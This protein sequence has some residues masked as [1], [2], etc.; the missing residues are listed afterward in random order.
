MM[1]PRKRFFLCFFATLVFFKAEAQDA[2]FRPPAV[3]LV[4]HDPYFSIWSMADHL[5]DESTRHWTGTPHPLNCLL[6]IDGKAYRIMGKTASPIPPLPQTGLRVYPTRSVYEFAGEGVRLTMTFLS[7]LLADRPELLARPISYITWRFA[8]T[9]GKEHQLSV[10]L[11]AGAEIAVNTR[12][13]AVTWARLQWGDLQAVRLGSQAQPILAKAGDDLRIDWGNLYLAAPG[14]HVS[15]VIANR[16]GAQE[17]FAQ[18]GSL[19]LQDAVEDPLLLHKSRSG[20]PALICRIDLGRVTAQPV[21]RFII[22]GYDDLFSVELF[23]QSLQ[24]YWRKQFEDFAALLSAAA[25][26]H[27][28]LETESK[29]FDETLWKRA[30]ASGGEQYAQIVSLAY[31][32]T[33]GGMKL[34]MLPDGSPVLFPKEN[35][36]NGCISTVDVIYPSAPF[37]LLLNPDLLAGQLRPVFDYA[38][39]SRWRFPFA[40]HDLGT[41]PQ[42]NGQVYGGREESERD[43]MPVEETGNMLIMTAALAKVTGRTELADRYW[44][45]LTRWAEYLQQK[46]FDPANQLATNEMA[47]HLE[48][49]TDLSIKAILGLGAYSELCRR[50]KRVGEA[51]HYLSTAKQYAE[52]WIT[53]ANDGDHF[54]LAFDRPRTWSQKHNLIWDKILGLHLF[55]NRVA[56]TELSFYQSKLGP[57]GLPYD[58]RTKQSLIDW[59]IWSASLA[60][61]RDEFET[62]VRPIY[63]FLNETPNRVPMTDWYLTES[64]KQVRYSPDRGFQA[65]TV[66]GGVFSRMLVEAG[67]SAPAPRSR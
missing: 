57:F 40:P 14:P 41:Y 67:Q 62:F 49:N 36:S 51:E 17:A 52:T 33:L 37:F 61:S 43:Q 63:R 20:A 25:T 10:Y 12:D 56:E 15:Y 9:D 30:V 48:H 66:V 29:Q 8:A 59:T 55:P 54:R 60:S 28:A 64:G 2:L 39:M 27:D 3:P 26:D 21:S 34:A 1:L 11:D 18:N 35:F 6:R 16:E 65:R 7:P 23:H 44:D 32:Q 31:R 4:V 24:P 22:L 58:S 53:K 45:L 47:G 5:S 46:G 19:P 42:A 50:T 13:Q 38:R